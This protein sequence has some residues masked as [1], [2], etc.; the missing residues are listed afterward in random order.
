M[1]F[2]LYP[3]DCKLLIRLVYFLFTGRESGSVEMVFHIRERFFPYSG[4]TG[5]TFLVK[6]SYRLWSLSDIFFSRNVLPVIP[7]YGKNLSRMWKTI[8][9]LPDSLP[10]NKKID[11]SN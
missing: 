6:P 9:T 8:S 11:Q 10:V 3:L 4:I 5:R 7:E 2:P 1:P